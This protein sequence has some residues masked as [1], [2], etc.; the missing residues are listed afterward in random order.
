MR[1][2]VLAAPST[3]TPFTSGLTQRANADKVTR[4]LGFKGKADARNEVI[5]R[6]RDQY[7][8]EL[9]FSSIIIE[10]IFI[11]TPLSIGCGSQ[12]G[13][14]FHPNGHTVVHQ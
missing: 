6:V 4:V 8:G 2:V 9:L 1:Q 10:L 13:A 3:S 7:A 14:E 12:T 11:L 5:G